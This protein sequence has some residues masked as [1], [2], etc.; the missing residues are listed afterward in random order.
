[1]V[2]IEEDKLIITIDH[3]VPKE[4]LKGLQM[5]I[6]VCMQTKPPDEDYGYFLMELLKQTMDLEDCTKS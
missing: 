3:V 5:E 6:I 1:M 2:T 4:M